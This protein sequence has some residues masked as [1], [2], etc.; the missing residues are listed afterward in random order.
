[1]ARVSQ[2]FLLQKGIP[3]T[4]NIATCYF[5]D[6]LCIG[7]FICL[8]G[9]IVCFRGFIEQRAVSGPTL[10]ADVWD[11]PEENTIV[12]KFNDRGQPIDEKGRMLASF[13]RDHGKKWC[14]NSFEF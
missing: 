13:F 7:N 14:T 8:R 6:C 12:V 10:L 3:P 2:L 11:M 1:M 9:S 5:D 4:S